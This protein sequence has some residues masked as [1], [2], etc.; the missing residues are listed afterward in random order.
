[1]ACLCGKIAVIC[2]IRRVPLNSNMVIKFD[3]NKHPRCK[4]LQTYHKNLYC[5][6]RI[7]KTKSCLV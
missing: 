7:Y 1:M 5:E 2:F 6:T 4:L 3:G